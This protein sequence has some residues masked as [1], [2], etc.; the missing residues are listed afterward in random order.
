MAHLGRELCGHPGFVHGGLLAV[1]F[2][3]VF[4]RCACPCLPKGIAVTANLNVDYRS[5]G[6]PDRLYVLQART[7][8]VEGRKAWVEGTLEMLP[9]TTTDQQSGSGDDSSAPVLVAEAKALFVEPKFAE[10][11]IN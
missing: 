4:A 11:C 5:P 6:H 8:E 3:E 7:V 1:L 10:V 2:D 9:Q